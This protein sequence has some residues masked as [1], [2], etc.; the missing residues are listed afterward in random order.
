MQNQPDFK[1]IFEKAILEL[2]Q[3]ISTKDIKK[4]DSILTQSTVPMEI[5]QDI[6]LVFPQFSQIFKSLIEQ[7]TY[8]N[9]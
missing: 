4:L 5:I 9:H 1:D 2:C 8:A 7:S 6:V 3:K